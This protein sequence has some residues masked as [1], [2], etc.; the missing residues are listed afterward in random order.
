MPS[1]VPDPHEATRRLLDFCRREGWAGYDPFDA[2]NSR[3]FQALPFLH[4]RWPRLILTQAFK[5]SPINLRPLFLVPKGVNPKGAAL[6]LA[7]LVQLEKVGLA[8]LDEVREMAN[9]LVSL[10]SPLS[11][12]AAWGYNFD[13]QSR[14]YLIPLGT[15]NIICTSFAGE[16]LLDAYHRL[17]DPQLLDLATQAGW[18]LLE[19]LQRSPLE[20]SFCLSYTPLRPSRVHNA[21]LLGGA[22]LARLH[23]LTQIPDFQSAALAIA[24]YGI[25]HQQP[26]GS[27]IYGEDPNQGWIDSFHTGYNL[28]A[29][30]GISHYLADPASQSSL[31][32]GFEYY[33]NHF[34]EPNGVVKYYHDRT[35]PIDTHGTAHAILTL[36]QLAHLHPANLD[37]ARHVLRWALEHMRHPNGHFYYQK[38]PSHTNRLIYMRWTQAWMLRGLAEFVAHAHQSLPLSTP[39]TESSP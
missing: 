17:Q 26:D 2:L 38:T 36:V 3:L 27:W 30:H 22:L 5:R 13:W 14:S 6:F 28:L 29:L 18:F 9:R 34:F 25:R 1:P 10:R 7:S 37:L 15:P 12:R 32:R 33:R 35:Y 31:R 8:S 11:Q 20:D 19:G 4:A 16:A 23:A 39:S 24:R 21:S